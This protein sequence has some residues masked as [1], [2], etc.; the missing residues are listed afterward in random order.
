MAT[1]PTHFDSLMRAWDAATA[2]AGTRHGFY[3]R[4]LA[5]PEPQCVFAGVTRP[6][7][8]RRVSFEVAAITGLT[9]LNDRTRG[10]TISTEPG[11]ADRPDRIVV[12]VSEADPR[13]P[14]PIFAL[15]GADLIHSVAGSNNPAASARS[16]LRRLQ[17][18]RLFFKATPDGGLSLLEAIGLFAEIDALSAWISGG[19]PPETAVTAWNGPLGGNQDFNHQGCGLEIKGTTANT[20]DSIV[21]ASARQL[22]D[23]GL[24]RLLLRHSA[25][26]FRD[27]AGTTLTAAVARLR[28]TLATSADATIAF[29]DRLLAAGYL[30]PLPRLLQSHGFTLRRHRHFRIEPGFPRLL[31]T[32]LPDG[33]TEVSYR[34]S[35]AACADFEI[36]ETEAFKLL[37]S[38]EMK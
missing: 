27:G 11:G 25:Y 7:G 13:S 19:T 15:L 24:D 33:V 23:T 28:M 34:V 14:E 16:L 9:S 20:I 12:N 22:D 35:L 21:I 8:L 31:E 17:H 37:G 30:E 38:Q 26:D 1:T 6:E 4:R 3:R 18:W 2:D 32:S 5:P 10:Y 29:E 36:G